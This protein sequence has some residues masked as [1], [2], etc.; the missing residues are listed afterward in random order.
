MPSLF[1]PSA[2]A[3]VEAAAAGLPSIGTRHGGSADLI[4]AGGVV[5]DPESEDAIV[6]ALRLLADAGRAEALGDRAWERAPLFTWE[7][8]AQRLLRPLGRNTRT[9]EY[10]ESPATAEVAA[11]TTQLQPARR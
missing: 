5:V 8:V 6:A 11:G 7:A 2:I 10:L 3:Y 4:G 1:E 9:I